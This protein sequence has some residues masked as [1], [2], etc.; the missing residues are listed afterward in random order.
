MRGVI[1]VSVMVVS[2]LGWLALAGPVDE[3]PAPFLP[4]EH[5]IGGWKGTAQ[6][7]AN[8]FKGW[9]ETHGWA[10]KFEKGRP[11]GM[12]VTLD[13]DKTLTKGQ[14]TYD[15][16]AKKYHLKGTDAAGKPVEFVGGFSPD[17]KVLTFDRV[18]ET[19][20]GKERLVIR[21]NS[22]KI[23]YTLQADLQ[24]PGAPQ[25]KNV[26]TVGLTKEGESF[27]AGAGGADLPKCILTGG[28]ASMTVSYQGK[29]YPVCCTGCRDEFNDDPAKYAAK[30]DLVAKADAGKD[31][32]AAKPAAKGK[33]D[34]SFDGLFDEPRAKTSAPTTSKAAPKAKA[35]A[36]AEAAEPSDSAKAAPA[37][38]DAEVK[39]GRELRLGQ[40]FEKNGKKAIA[41]DHYR[42]IVKDFPATDAAKTA[43]AR[44][45][46]LEPR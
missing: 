44:I 33:D 7:T 17:G 5:M 2:A 4:F 42:K 46:A 24:E 3:V 27:A 22:N 1:A 26:I 39:A 29:S 35:E 6:P 28:A 11:V 36:V 21:P 16:G 14:L 32:S 34:G 18:G 38:D 8:K 12:T 41:L 40:N 9:Q 45:K 30:A 19:P 15:E 37:K 25:Y 20:E 43:A 10:W 23:R 13:G 31:K